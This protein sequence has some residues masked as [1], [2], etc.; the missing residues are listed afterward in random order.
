MRF[1]RLEQRLEDMVLVSNRDRIFRIADSLGDEMPRGQID[2]LNKFRYMV[3]H[4]SNALEAKHPEFSLALNSLNTVRT[5]AAARLD[6]GYDWRVPHVLAARRQCLDLH[7][8]VR[9][10]PLHGRGAR[11]RHSRRNRHGKRLSDTGQ[12]STK[13]F[14]LGRNRPFFLTQLGLDARFFV[15]Y[16]M[17]AVG[18][19]KC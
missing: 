14:F 15:G 17:A 12:T 19:R 7:R 16:Y 4:A 8:P 1:D 11:K 3:A 13:T 10:A 6:H 9:L 18:F 2:V 5:A